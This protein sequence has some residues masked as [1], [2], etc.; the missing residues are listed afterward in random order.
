MSYVPKEAFGQDVH[1]KI[2]QFSRDV[3]NVIV[4]AK[5]PFGSDKFDPQLALAFASQLHEIFESVAGRNGKTKL[6]VTTRKHIWLEVCTE[7]KLSSL[8]MKRVSFEIQNPIAENWKN[9]LNTHLRRNLLSVQ[10]IDQIAKHLRD[11]RFFENPLHIREFAA[12]VK[13]MHTADGYIGQAFEESRPSLYH[14]WA[15][16]QNE[17]TKVI[18][19]AARLLI[20]EFSDTQLAGLK[21]IIPIVDEF[22]FGLNTSVNHKRELQES[23]DTLQVTHRLMQIG[24]RLQLVHPLFTQAIGQLFETYAKLDKQEFR[25]FIDRLLD[26][27]IIEHRV[28]AA[29][30][31]YANL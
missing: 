27:D 23:L 21:S 29:S 26:S 28:I 11:G 7:V 19:F 20:A 14:R 10:D 25:N 13:T 30:R 31:R 12:A 16:I 2:Y 18:L 8:I 3:D 15:K 22:V 4:I 9:I 17:P 1:L 6:V 24:N 5:N